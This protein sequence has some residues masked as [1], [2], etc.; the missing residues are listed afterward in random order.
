MLTYYNKTQYS[1]IF[2]LLQTKIQKIYTFL[3]VIWGFLLKIIFMTNLDNKIG[4]LQN[5]IIIRK[6]GV[7]ILI[8]VMKVI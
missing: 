7:I 3:S 1:K 2:T 5:N 8:Y 4:C 6:Y